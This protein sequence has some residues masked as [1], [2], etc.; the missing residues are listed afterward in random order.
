MASAIH[1]VDIS[2]TLRIFVMFSEKFTTAMTLRSTRKSLNAMSPARAQPVSFASTSV[3]L[4][5]SYSL[6]I[7]IP[8]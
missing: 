3:V 1:K 7:M 6:F 4:V 5:F 8:L 2:K